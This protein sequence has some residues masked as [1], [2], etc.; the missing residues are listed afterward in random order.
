MVHLSV[1]VCRCVWIYV[2]LRL[3]GSV[4]TRGLQLAVWAGRWEI[5]FV[6]CMRSNREHG[7]VLVLKQLGLELVSSLGS[8]D[9]DGGPCPKVIG[10]SSG[11]AD[12]RRREMAAAGVWR[13]LNLK[14]HASA[15]SYEARVRDEPMAGQGF[16]DARSMLRRRP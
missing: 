13:K 4:W 14:D 2:R 15:C 1:I 6:A 3:D 16:V 5:I 10:Y 12:V 11:C 9:R 8:D 7:A